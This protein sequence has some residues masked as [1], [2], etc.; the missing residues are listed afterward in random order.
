MIAAWNKIA[1]E[2]AYSEDAFFTFKGHRAISMMHLAM[3]DALNTID[4]RYTRYACAAAPT[5]AEPTTAAVQA[6]YEVLVT[7]YPDR[8]SSLQPVDR[9]LTRRRSLHVPKTFRPGTMT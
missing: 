7:Q 1:Y 2:I 6:A 9:W 8:R 4:R 3:H 5:E